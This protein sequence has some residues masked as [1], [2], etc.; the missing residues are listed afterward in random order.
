MGK[1]SGRV[2][3][4]SS[5]RPRSTGGSST[6][7]DDILAAARSVLMVDYAVYRWEDG[8]VVVWRRGPPPRAGVRIT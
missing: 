6:S 7:P 8:Q 1:P 4:Y 2:V 3:A 5:R